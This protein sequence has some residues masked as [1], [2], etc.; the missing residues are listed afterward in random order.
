MSFRA[1]VQKRRITA[2]PAGD[3]V[4]DARFDRTFPDP[5]TWEELDH[6]LFTRFACSGA[7]K[8]AKQVWR[9]YK[10]SQRRQSRQCPEASEA[11]SDRPT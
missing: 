1:F 4:E 3:F 7:I 2:N 11:R 8:A 10:A 6:Y 9:E 5:G